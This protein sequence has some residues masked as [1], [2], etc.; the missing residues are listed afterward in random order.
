MS[1][2]FPNVNL[3]VLNLLPILPQGGGRIVMGTLKRLF[4]P[5]RRLKLP[6][7]LVGVHRWG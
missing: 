4:P 2:L 6:L 7:T 5:V 1:C 3:A